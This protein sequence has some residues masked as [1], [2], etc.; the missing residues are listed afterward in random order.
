MSTPNLSSEIEINLQG[1]IAFVRIHGDLGTEEAQRL[2]PRLLSVTAS[3]PELAIL[4]LS[5]ANLVSSLGMGAI[6]EL[7]RGMVRFN[8]KVILM[9]MKPI[10]REC[11][12]LSGL[13]GLFGVAETLEEALLA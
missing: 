9:G 7:R 8:G 2:M 10:V 4:D 5:A 12:R 1:E 13:L 11:F 3:R 6:M